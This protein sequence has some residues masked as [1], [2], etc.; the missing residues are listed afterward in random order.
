MQL[1]APLLTPS[2]SFLPLICPDQPPDPTRTNATHEAVPHVQL[3]ASR[4][5]A[6]YPRLLAR[7]EPPVPCV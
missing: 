5:P 1:R 7:V 2:F 3:A 6:V 4:L